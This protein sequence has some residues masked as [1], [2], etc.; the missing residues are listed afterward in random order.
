MDRGRI[1][2]C[3][4]EMGAERN[5]LEDYR[6]FLLAADLD[7]RAAFQ[8]AIVEARSNL[9]MSSADIARLC[10]CAHPTVEIWSKGEAAPYHGMR[11]VI[12][13]RLAEIALQQSQRREN[14]E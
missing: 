10:K 14:G 13:E 1:A 2:V 12:F 8:H 11:K 9:D 3:G 4:G 7:D 6:A 5:T